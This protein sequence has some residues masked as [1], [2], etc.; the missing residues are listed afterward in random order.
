MATTTNAPLD[1][2]Y[3]HIPVHS[4]L[5]AYMRTTEAPIR[6]RLDSAFEGSFQ[7]TTTNVGDAV[8]HNS[9]MHHSGTGSGRQRELAWNSAGVHG[10][11][12]VAQG[13]ANWAPSLRPVELMGS[14][15]CSTTNRDIELSV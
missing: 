7:L 11:S 3:T 4:K 5:D 1:L 13:V 14:I 2:D 8:V 10:R 9:T 6:A 15:L 12:R